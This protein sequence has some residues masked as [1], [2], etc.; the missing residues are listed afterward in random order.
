MKQ[1]PVFC[2][3]KEGQKESINMTCYRFHFRYNVFNGRFFLLVLHYNDVNTIAPYR[4]SQEKKMYSDINVDVLCC[5]HERRVDV[6]R[7][8]PF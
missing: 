5:E 4:V 3:L 7:K 6:K 8:Q 2:S 1:V